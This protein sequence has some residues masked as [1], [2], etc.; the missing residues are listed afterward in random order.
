[1]REPLGEAEGESP[2]DP[3]AALAALPPDDEA[4]GAVPERV[5]VVVAHPDDVD[6]GAAGS[7]A[8][9]V[10]AGTKVAYCIVTDGSAGTVDPTIDLS[11][12][13]EIRQHEQR[14]AAR[15]VGVDEV[16]FLGYPDGQLEPTREVRRDLSRVIREVRPDRVLTQSPERNYERIRAS[17]PDHLAAGEATLR[18]VYPDARNPYAHPELLQAGFEPFEVPEVWLMAAPRSDRAVDIT[19][20][21][22]KKLAALASH[23]SQIADV[24]ALA[25]FVRGWAASTAARFGLGADRLAEAFQVVDTR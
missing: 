16:V 20:V 6:F 12:L 9:W 11:R 24:E 3:A 14:A 15:A 25:V 4:A 7:V 19:E 22:D 10:A 8:T 17:H 5:L 1:M 21:F 18:A 2:G 23:R 13:A